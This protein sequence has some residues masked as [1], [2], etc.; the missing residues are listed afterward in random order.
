MV[1]EPSQFGFGVVVGLG[2]G[3][4]VEF[5]T[6]VVV[7]VAIS[8]GV[9][10]GVDDHVVVGEVVGA[11]VGIS[12]SVGANVGIG[13]GVYVAVNVAVGVGDAT[14]KMIE[15]P[16]TRVDCRFNETVKRWI[17]GKHFSD[18]LTDL[19]SVLLSN[20]LKEMKAP[21]PGPS[22]SCSEVEM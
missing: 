6:G 2:V 8:A 15:F 9:L 14:S 11:G 18:S 7:V 13:V 10:V 21:I 3:V 22:Q 17:P 19:V 1:G 12:L 16:A 5:C 4:V 20:P